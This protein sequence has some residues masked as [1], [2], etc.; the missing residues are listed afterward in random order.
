MPSSIAA[1]HRTLADFRIW[2]RVEHIGVKQFLAIAS[3]APDEPAQRAIVLQTIS[4]SLAEANLERDRLMVEM[5][6]RVRARGDCVVDAE[7]G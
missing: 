4:P 7:K 6:A 5:G 1:L 3:A 2:G